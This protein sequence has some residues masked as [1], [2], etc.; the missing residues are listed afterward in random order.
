MS[1]EEQEYVVEFG[2]KVAS[3]HQ[4]HS[5]DAPVELEAQPAVSVTAAAAASNSEPQAL[6]VYVSFVDEGAAVPRS[7]STTAASVVGADAD[8]DFADVC[9]ENSRYFPLIGWTTNLLPTD[10][11]TLSDETGKV[12]K[13]RVYTRLICVCF[14]G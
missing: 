14:F 7:A 1:E 4:D 10:R 11:F 8:A 5:T 13:A 9:W 2:D 3:Y 12:Q 6:P